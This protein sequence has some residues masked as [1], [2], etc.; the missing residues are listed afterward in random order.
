MGFRKKEE[1]ICFLGGKLP[2]GHLVSLR[3]FSGKKL[4]KLQVPFFVSVRQSWVVAKR[5]L[6]VATSQRLLALL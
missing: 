6:I 1:E 5:K 2:S 3:F 4:H